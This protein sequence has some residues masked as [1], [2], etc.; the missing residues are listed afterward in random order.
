MSPTSIPQATA[1]STLPHLE[2]TIDNGGTYPSTTSFSPTH[3]EFLSMAFTVDVADGGFTI[4]TVDMNGKSLPVFIKLGKRISYTVY[5]S[6]RS[7]SVN[8]GFVILDDNAVQALFGK[9]GREKKHSLGN[10]LVAECILEEV[11]KGNFPARGFAPGDDKS[12]LGTRILSPTSEE[13][14]KIEVWPTTKRSVRTATSVGV[15]QISGLPISPTSANAFCRR[16]GASTP[17]RGRRSRTMP[18]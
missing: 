11:R 12:L 4:G 13:I 15:P 17:T 5:I 8:E 9:K 3:K 1:A 16:S 18:Q 7:N 2:P 6:G 10:R 14:Q